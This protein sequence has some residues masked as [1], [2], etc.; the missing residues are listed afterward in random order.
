MVNGAITLF[1][2]VDIN[3]DGRL[4]W[5]EFIRYI[6]DTVINESIVPTVDIVSGKYLTI[7]D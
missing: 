3:S 5:V 4:E 6:I 2:D 7:G 1:K